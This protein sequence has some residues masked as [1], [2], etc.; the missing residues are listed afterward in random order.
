MFLFALFQAEQNPKIKIIR[1]D[2]SLYASNFAFFKRKLYELIGLKIEQ[3]PIIKYRKPETTNINEFQ[4]K[5]VI[6][7]CSP[8]NF[9]DTVGVKTLIEVS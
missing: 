9:I 7:D 5:Y 8:F 1:F 4:I 6:L 3:T 2:G